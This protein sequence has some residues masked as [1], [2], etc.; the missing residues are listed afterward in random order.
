M[1]T[2][3]E[4]HVRIAAF[5]GV[6]EAALPAADGSKHSFLPAVVAVVVAVH[7][8]RLDVCKKMR[9][10]NGPD[11]VLHR[12]VDILAVVVVHHSRTVRVV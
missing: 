11:T 10:C 8:S 5:A 6:E 7:V 1:N 9:P 2:Q 12:I 4:R 3:Q